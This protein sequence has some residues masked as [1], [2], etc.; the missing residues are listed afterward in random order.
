MGIGV[1]EEAVGE[2]GSSCASVRDNQRIARRTD[3]V[4]CRGMRNPLPQAGQR[5]VVV[6]RVGVDS[7]KVSVRW[8]RCASGGVLP[9]RMEIV[10][11]TLFY[12]SS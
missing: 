4:R 6:W 2:V 11:S 9:K 1:G 10:S 5:V 7:R 8:R 12:I 3:S